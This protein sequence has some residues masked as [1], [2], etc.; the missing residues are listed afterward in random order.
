MSNTDRIDLTTIRE[1]SPNEHSQMG[2]NQDK[3][4]EPFPGTW[5][6][7]ECGADNPALVGTCKVCGKPNMMLFPSP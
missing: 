7:H 2:G 5:T 3:S 6:C 4:N 1:P